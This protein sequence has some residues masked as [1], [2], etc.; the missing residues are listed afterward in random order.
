M[1][2]FPI[3]NNTD[4]TAAIITQAGNKQFWKF[5]KNFR[6]FSTK[7]KSLHADCG[8]AE[9]EL[10]S[11]DRH[12]RVRFVD[13]THW[14]QVSREVTTPSRV[15]LENLTGAQPPMTLPAFY[16]IRGFFTVLTTARHTPITNDVYPA[17][18]LSLVSFTSISILSAIYTKIFLR[19][20]F[21]KVLRQKPVT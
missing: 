14:T 5:W 12:K 11:S 20:S 4:V 1:F 2:Q 19:I 8:L 3:I 10:L 7:I 15:L 17:H 18:S 13:L 16:A 9:T 21:F 6:K